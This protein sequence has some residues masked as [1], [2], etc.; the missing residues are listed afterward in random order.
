M[1]KFILWGC[2]SNTENVIRSYNFYDFDAI[3]A[4]VDNDPN[5]WGVKYLGKIVVS[6]DEIYE[7][8]SNYIFVGSDLFYDEICK[9][10]SKMKI[11]KTI[12]R[13]S[14]GINELWLKEAGNIPQ[15]LMADA[16][17]LSSRYEAIKLMP[18][19]LTVAELGVAY[20]DFSEFIINEMKPNKFY[21]IDYFN[22]N[23]P[24]ERILG[25]NT[26][27]QEGIPHEKWYRN[28]FKECISSGL[29]EI[30]SGLSWECMERFEDDYF[31]YVYV[32]A[33]HDYE[34]VKKD[35]EVIVRKVK[36]GGYIQFND[37]IFH[38]FSS[39]YYYGVIPAANEMVKETGSQVVY[40]CLNYHCYDDIVIKLNKKD[41]M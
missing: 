18:K 7:L 28:R 34:S 22:K 30:C 32:D 31:D 19:G 1:E 11:E 20:G 8:N 37:Y 5:K 25:K 16:K 4:I 38:D 26:F 9:Q 35:I 17:L 6:P 12:M 14:R 27:L 13:L 40:Y 24:F 29:M 15:E 36:H 2:G 41:K 33:G 3:E 39:D 21:A 23:N 10:I